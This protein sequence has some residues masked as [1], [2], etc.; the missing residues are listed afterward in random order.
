MDASHE[1]RTPLMS[2][3]TNIDVLR[4]GHD[5]D[6]QDQAAVVDDLDTELSELSELVVELVD[7]AVDVRSDE[8]PV[9]LRLE[10][11]A[12]PVVERARRRVERDIEVSV[13]RSAVL[14]SRPEALG[15]AIRN[16][17]ENAAKFSPT[18]SP[19]RVV[20]DG[21]MLAVHDSGPGIPEAE[22]E[23]VFARF[24]RLDSSQALPGSG[25]GLAIVRDVVDVHGGSVFV[26]DSPEGGAAVGF[27]LPTIDD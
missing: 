17:V 19:I 16:L 12:L 6:E 18:D 20:I 4:R 15:R 3:R 22:R 13:E 5:L 11:I 8:D 9:P 26:T 2:L 25:L 21:G 23:A 27:H 10:E 24:H 7:L 1:L 14:E